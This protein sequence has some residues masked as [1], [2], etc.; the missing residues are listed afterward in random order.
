[1]E[2]DFA[3]WDS[4]K[5]APVNDARIEFMD[6]LGYIYL[7]HGLPDKAAVLLAARNVLQPGNA[8]TLLT[9]AVA[10]VRSEKPNKALETLEQLAM[11]G[12]M[13]AYFHLVRAQALQMSGR[14]EE[15]STAM[16]AHISLRSARASVESPSTHAGPGDNQ[17]IA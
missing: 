10:Q 2:Q 17:G 8:Q 15:A 3:D 4:S 9:L 12:G 1:M 5:A 16:R 11:Q 6:L 13:D 14:T 7:Q